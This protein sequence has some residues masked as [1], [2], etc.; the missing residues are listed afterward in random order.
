MARKPLSGTVAANCQEHGCGALN[1]DG[2]RIP[3]AKPDTTRGSG[4][5]KGA[6]SPLPAQGRILDD[7]LG[8]FPA[9]LIHDGSDEVL[10]CFPDAPGQIAGVKYGPEE[11]KTKGVYGTMK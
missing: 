4:G 9:N 2:C 7:G 5:G 3:G 10:A 6:Y 11:Y 1:I 8:R